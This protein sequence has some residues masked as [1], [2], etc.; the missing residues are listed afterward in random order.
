MRDREREEREEGD[1]TYISQQEGKISSTIGS[2]VA[3]YETSYA[4]QR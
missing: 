3:V 2:V 4:L 1:R